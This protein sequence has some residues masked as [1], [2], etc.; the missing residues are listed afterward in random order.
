MAATGDYDAVFCGHSHRAAV[1]ELDNVK[2]GRTPWSIRGRSLTQRQRRWCS[3]IVHCHSRA[4]AKSVAR[5][6]E[7]F[8]D[9]ARTKPKFKASHPGGSSA[10][11]S[12]A[13]PLWSTLCCLHSHSRPS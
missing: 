9:F 8:A 13:L 6:N 1:E 7:Q 4:G 12:L 11:R 3:A 5:A 2:G 10:L